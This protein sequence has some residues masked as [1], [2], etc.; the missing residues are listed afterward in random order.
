MTTHKI[1]HI[2]TLSRQYLVGQGYERRVH[3][4]LGQGIEPFGFT[5][6]GAFALKFNMRG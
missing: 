5:I 3:L 6:A 2:L 1:A 4:S